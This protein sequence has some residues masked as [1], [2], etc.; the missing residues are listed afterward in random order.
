MPEEDKI[1]DRLAAKHGASKNDVVRK[2]LRLLA[3]IE[4]LSDEGDRLIV[5]RRGR[6]D[7]REALEV[8]VL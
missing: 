2:A 1:V 3:K 4:K 6:N 5:E 8:W 7:D